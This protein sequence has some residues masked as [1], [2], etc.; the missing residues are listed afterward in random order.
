MRRG[1]DD[2]AETKVAVTGDRLRILGV[3]DQN[4]FG[5]PP[6]TS[7]LVAAR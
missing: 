7:R 4:A 3:A 2:G 5:S 1:F 6:S